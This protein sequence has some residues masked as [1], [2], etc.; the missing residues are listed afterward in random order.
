MAVSLDQIIMGVYGGTFDQPLARFQ[1]YL[2]EA[3]RPAVGFDSAI[4][5]T[6]VHA[7]N[8]IN[9]LWYHRREPVN[10]PAYLHRFTALDT[11]RDA[12]L[13]S[14]G[15]AFRIEDTRD[16]ADYYASEVYREIGR[17]GRMEQVMGISLF[18]AI[19]RLSHYVIV[20]GHD[21]ARPFAP[22]HRDALE[23]LTP[24]LVAA[25]RHR[26]LADML[27]RPLPR[28]GGDQRGLCGRA[29]ADYRG[30]VEA[31]D[32]GFAA[33]LVSAFPGWR[34][35]RLPGPLC[36]LIAG[37][38]DEATIGGLGIRVARSTQSCVLTLADTGP[39][40][41]LT[42]AERRAAQLYAGGATQGA[43]ARS[44]GTSRHTVRNQLATVY[45]KL[46]VHTKVELARHFPAA[47][48]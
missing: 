45:D 33:A 22:S 31:A 36:D 28:G 15:K 43:I 34:G 40:A 20:Y 44:L 47:H 21:R 10:V 2:F 11:V 18:N 14:P 25:W 6:G 27:Q 38:G 3:I 23:R 39:L 9:S 13:A 16:L 37:G 30:T 26:Q 29:I 41:E 4:W 42:A 12:A 32:D 7:S 24:H 17:Q 5:I 46:G 19:T 48:D 1:D 35:P 8:Q